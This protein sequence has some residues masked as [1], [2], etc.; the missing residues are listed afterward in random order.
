MWMRNKWSEIILKLSLIPKNKLYVLVGSVLVIIILLVTVGVKTVGAIREKNRL[1]AVEQEQSSN[2]SIF[3]VEKNSGTEVVPTTNTPDASTQT[4]A[5]VNSGTSSTPSTSSG[6]ATN[7]SDSTSSGGTT[8]VSDSTSSGDTTNSSSSSSSG[9]SSSG[10]ATLSSCGSSYSFFDHDPTDMSEFAN[11]APLGN[12]NPSGHV[13]PTD[14]I[15]FYHSSNNT[16]TVYAPG[17]AT[18]TRISASENQT[19]GTTDYSIYF[20]PCSELEVYYLHISTMSQKLLDAF[21]APF[22]WDSTYST[23][24]STYRNYGRNVNV[25]LASGETVGTF[26][27]QYAFDMGA[28]DTRITLNFVNPNARLN[29][30]HTV[31]PLDYYSDSLKATLYGYLGS[32]ASNKRTVAPLCGTVDQ[33]VAGTAQGVWLLAGTTQVNGED[34]HLALV[35]GNTDPTQATFSVGTS[36]GASGLSSGVYTFTPSGGSYNKDFNAV[37]VDSGPQCYRAERNGAQTI[38]IQLTSATTLKIEKL[39]GDCDTPRSFTGNETSFQ[40]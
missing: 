27:G 23:G 10:T 8:T 29:S 11:I 15:Y 13:F 2:D 24:G 25:V 30:T 16:S 26:T 19:A 7:S 32:S 31:C 12:L 6:G 9:S 3:E 40:R 18:V 14:H 35:H 36:V 38:L 33:D 28:Y 34:T 20:N 21:V 39:D 5:G 22:S 4:T 17:S 1:R 37:T